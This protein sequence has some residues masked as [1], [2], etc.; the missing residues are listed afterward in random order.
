MTTPPEAHGDERGALLAALASQRAAFRQAVEGLTEEQARSTPSASEL[1]LA[2]VIKHVTAVETGWLATMRDGVRPDYTDPA[3]FET[4]AASFVPTE[5]ETVA[6]LLD[7]YD[8][9]AAE[10]EKAVH[11]LPSLNDTFMLPDAPWGEGGP[12]SWRWALLHLIEEAAR[13]AGHADVIRETIDGH[14]AMG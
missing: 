5:D 2:G 1:S 3:T 6:V 14:K 8:Q 10:T 7:R 4:H 13:H 12:R 9:A 11:D